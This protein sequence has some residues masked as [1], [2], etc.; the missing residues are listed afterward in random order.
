[1]THR[2][3]QSLLNDSVD[4]VLSVELRSALAEHLAQCTTCRR[5]F[6]ELRVLL[7]VAR[8]LPREIS[9]ERNLWPGVQVAIRPRS[10]WQVLRA[11]HPFPAIAAA[12]ATLAVIL[13]ISLGPPD[14]GQ[15][16]QP[17]SPCIA[18]MLHA[19]ET[20]CRIS[21]RELR[22]YLTAD[23]DPVSAPGLDVINENLVTLDHAIAEARTAWVA[24]T[25]RTLWGLRLAQH[26]RTKLALQEHALRLATNT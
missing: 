19:L 21:D 2:E 12:T 23:P 25:G 4:G 9:P 17:E 26:Y 24:D 20:E 8:T 3:A 11:Y 22:A 16:D 6:E 5:D 13:F 15:V 10:F 14:R 18:A 1:M 7:A